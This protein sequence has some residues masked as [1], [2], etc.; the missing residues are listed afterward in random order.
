MESRAF[1]DRAGGLLQTCMLLSLNCGF[2]AV[3]IATLKHSEVDWVAGTITKKRVKTGGQSNVPTVTWVLWKTTLAQLKKHRATH[4][5][6]VLLGRKDRELIVGGGLER[7]DTIADMWRWVKKC[8]GSKHPFKLLR[9]T[10]ASILGGSPAYGRYAQYFLSHAAS[11]TADRHYVRPSQV[12][13]DKAV[14]W[15]GKELRFQ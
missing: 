11:T 15:L 8:L 5:E 13:F 2:N 7:S 3:D 4:P 1:Y 12:E 9:K 6:L 14:K 10:S